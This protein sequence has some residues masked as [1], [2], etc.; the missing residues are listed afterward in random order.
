MLAIPQEHVLE[1]MLSKK[2]VYSIDQYDTIIK[3]TTVVLWGM[4]WHDVFDRN[5]SV[6]LYQYNSI[7]VSLQ[8]QQ[9]M[10]VS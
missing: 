3:L 1:V 9:Y 6:V 2:V 8:T 10:Y 7:L 4:Q 5:H